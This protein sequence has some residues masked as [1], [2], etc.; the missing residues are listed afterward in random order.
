[1]RD[2]KFYYVYIMA[3]RSRTL[4]TGVTNRI[5]RRAMQ[6]KE[7][8]IEG[9]TKKYNINRLV[10]Y[11]IFKYVTNAI[12]REK[13]VK[14][15]T[16]AKRLALIESTNPTWQDL[17]EGWGE[18]LQIPHCIRD[19]KGL[20]VEDVPER[21]RESAEASRENPDTSEGLKKSEG[22]EKREGSENSKRGRRKR[23]ASAIK[24]R[25]ALAHQGVLHD[26]IVPTPNPCHPER[27]EGSAVRRQRP[28]TLGEQHRYRPYRGDAGGVETLRVPAPFLAAI[29]IVQGMN[30]QEKNPWIVDRICGRVEHVQRIPIKK[31]PNNYTEKRKDLKGI[32]LELYESPGGAPCCDALKKVGS[33][34][35]GKGGS[36]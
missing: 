13:Q 25:P 5:Y 28:G 16:R 4:C 10:Y 24:A 9:F 30:A 23:R 29:L 15:W 2:E 33:T 1:M 31:Q 27:S 6:H 32:P 12:A 22:L 36:I 17:A 3:S 21:A 35:S 18:Q 14:A 26:A 19:D 20:R 7:G 8:E 11:E 34:I